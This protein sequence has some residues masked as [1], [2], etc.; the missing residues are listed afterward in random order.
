M[1]DI[2]EVEGLIYFFTRGKG[3]ESHS[4][5]GYFYPSKGSQT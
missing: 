3:S 1:E 5:Y 2:L 4:D